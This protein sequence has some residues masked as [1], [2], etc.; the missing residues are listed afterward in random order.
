[1]TPKECEERALDLF[2]EIAR[3]LEG[4]VEPWHMMEICDL[5]RD[6]LRTTVAK[7]REAER[8]ACAQLAEAPYSD[9]VAARAGEELFAVGGK[10]AAAIRARSVEETS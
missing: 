8:E 2:M 5:T 6:A 7:E 1:M 4:K 3:V 9:P 10:I